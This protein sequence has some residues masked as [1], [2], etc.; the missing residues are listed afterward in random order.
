MNADLSVFSASEFNSA[1]WI[2]KIISDLPENENIETFI[3]SVNMKLHMTGQ[4]YSE[5]LETAM[6]ESMSTIPRVVLEINRLQDQLH[7][8]QDEMKLI[9]QHI[10]SV[11]QRS[12]HG[13]EELS[14]LDHIKT[15]ME[16]CRS[17]LEEH[18]RWNQLAREARVLLE[19]SG[20][21]SETADR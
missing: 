3:S 21:L 15:N 4:D 13:V 9:S 5:Q 20:D 2:N 14:R 7:S 16:S 11:D 17:T 1:D 6:I 18:T 19:G 10:H 12:V 8:V